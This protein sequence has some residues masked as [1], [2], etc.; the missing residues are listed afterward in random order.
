MSSDAVS[1]SGSGSGSREDPLDQ[2]KKKQ[3]EQKHMELKEKLKRLKSVNNSGANDDANS[4]DSVKHEKE[5]SS[6]KEATTEQAKSDNKSKFFQLKEKLRKLKEEYSARWVGRASESVRSASSRRS[7]RSNGNDNGNDKAGSPP[8]SRETT[9]REPAP[10]QKDR[11]TLR[12]ELKKK[13]EKFK[14]ENGICDGENGRAAEEEEQSVSQDRS[15][16]K[17]YPNRKNRKRPRGGSNSTINRSTSRGVKKRPSY[18]SRELYMPPNRNRIN[19]YNPNERYRR[20]ASNSPR[21]S[22]AERDHRRDYRGRMVPRRDSPSYEERFRR[23]MHDSPRRGRSRDRDRS[24]DRIRSGDRHRRSKERDSWRDRHNTSLN[25]RERGSQLRD[26]DHAHFRREERQNRYLYNQRTGE[27]VEKKYFRHKIFRRSKSLSPSTWKKFVPND[28]DADGASSRCDREG[29]ADNKRDEKHK[30]KHRK[31]EKTQKGKHRKGDSYVDRRSDEDDNA[32]RKRNGTSSRSRSRLRGEKGKYNNNDTSH[33][34]KRGGKKYSKS[35]SSG[36]GVENE[37]SLEKGKRRS[38]VERRKSKKEKKSS[39]KDNHR[40]YRSSSRSSSNYSDS[41]KRDK[42][43]HKHR[44]HEEVKRRSEKERKEKKKRKSKH[45]EKK[46]K[47]NSKHEESKKKSKRRNKHKRGSDYSD[48][49]GEKSDAAATSATSATSLSFL[50]EGYDSLHDVDV[51][52]EGVCEKGKKSEES[53][54][55]VN[56]TEESK[57][58]VNETE[59][60][61]ME[62]NETEE[63]EEEL[64]EAQEGE[65]SSGEGSDVGPKP[66]DVNVKLANQQID[67]GVAMMPGEGQAIA[68][69]VQKGKRIPRRGEVGLSAEA[70]ENFESLGYVMSGSRHKRMNAIRMRKENQVYSAEEQRALAMFNYE[71]RANRENAL[72]SDLKEVLR[73]QNEAILNES[74]NN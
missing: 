49:D 31:G 16:S 52:K 6:P 11:E 57:M 58:E 10:M 73:K 60:S 5:S 40:R 35:V 72:I 19:R 68:Q 71:E 50:C 22:S 63:K 34:R 29:K 3:F 48:S 2:L 39:R 47:K 65:D 14:R 62:V 51:S 64:L 28:D 9:K 27:K 66:L 36:G 43:K 38:S 74:K 69:F 32:G 45:E 42:K 56:E 67:Y 24:R 26:D 12:A 23:G 7:E 30:H 46:K 15:L 53:K 21:F 59:E 13:L 44:K 37:R 17:G 25:A 70:I 61:K 33:R 41:H 8:P 55:E 54:I 4:A 1:S 18:D 20:G